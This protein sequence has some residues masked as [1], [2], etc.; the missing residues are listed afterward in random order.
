MHTDLIKL[1]CD[2]KANDLVVLTFIIQITNLDCVAAGGIRVLQTN[3]FR[4]ASN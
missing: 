4:I 1:S 2:N 3:L